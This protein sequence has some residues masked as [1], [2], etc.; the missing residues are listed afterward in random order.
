MP[1]LSER[2]Q[3]TLTYRIKG[4]FD[5]SL[6]KEFRAAH[7]SSPGIR[8]YILD[9][10]EAIYMDSSALGMMLLLREW[11]QERGAD[12]R[13]RTKAPIVKKILAMAHF[14]KLFPID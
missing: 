4:R 7:E 11:A 1:L 5:F 10:T 12:V 9:L 14:E 8:H 3:D 6:H 2:S 13:I